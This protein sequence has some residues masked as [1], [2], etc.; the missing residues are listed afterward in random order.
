MGDVLVARE[1]RFGQIR[2]VHRQMVARRDERLAEL[3]RLRAE[4]AHLR[5]YV[6]HHGRD[7]IDWG[8][9]RRVDP[10]SRDWGYDRG[11]P[12]DR[13][14]IDEFLS[15]H[16]SDVHGSVLEVQE[17]EFTRAYG[18]SRVTASTVLD[19][20]ASNT[21]ATVLA[22]LRCAPGIPADQYDCVILT[23]TL[24]VIDDMGSALRE[25]YRI[26]KPGGVIL[27]TMPAAS[28]V[29]LEYGHDGDF[30]RASPAGARALF[31]SAFSPATVAT[32]EFGNVLTN[33]AFLHG[34]ATVEVS[35]AEF[36]ARDP[37]FAVLTG[38]RARK[39]PYS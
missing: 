15:A 21:R 7:E 11:V 28:R 27:A 2:E 16:S 12:I 20:D 23:Q 25:C 1:V 3:D 18:G 38:I 32:S 24:H 4:A 36:D 13:R 10:I 34:G 30:W 35:D 9:L 33:V 5:A 6:A 39:G 8:D 17:D 19:I 31:R 22:D 14:Y 26:L 37:Y 29:C